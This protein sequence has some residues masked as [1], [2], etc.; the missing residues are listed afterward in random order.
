MHYLIDAR[1]E[2]GI[3]MVTIRDA[4]TGRVRLHWTRPGDR[5]GGQALHGLFNGLVLLSC[6][7][8]FNPPEEAQK[9]QS[10]AASDSVAAGTFPVPLMRRRCP[11]PLIMSQ[12]SRSGAGR[13]NPA[14]D[15]DAVIPRK[16]RHTAPP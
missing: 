13:S 12:S 9:T 14:E 7:D 3:P 16:Q 11:T 4:D 2:N 1:L 6:A 5:A 8:Q 15:N 10:V